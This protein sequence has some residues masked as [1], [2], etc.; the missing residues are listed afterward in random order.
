MKL[1]QFVGFGLA[2]L[3]LVACESDSSSGSGDDSAGRLLNIAG[4]NYQTETYS[5]V[6]TLSGGYDFEPGETV[7]FSL[8]GIELGTIEAQEELT[9]FEL[10][11]ENYGLPKTALDVRLQLRSFEGYRQYRSAPFRFDF[12]VAQGGD[13]SGIHYAANL[14]R[15][16]LSMD[17][18]QNFVNGI[19]LLPGDWATVLAEATLDLNKP[20]WEVAGLMD[21][22]TVK[23][24]HTYTVPW[25]ADN[26]LPL[27][28]LYEDAGVFITG[29]VLTGWTSDELYTDDFMRDEQ[30]RITETRYSNSTRSVIYRYTYDATGNLV[31]EERGTQLYEDNSLSN[32][33]IY[34]Y[35]F[36]QYAALTKYH[37]DRYDTVTNGEFGMP[38][39]QSTNTYSYQDG[40]ALRTDRL[41]ESINSEGV[42]SSAAQYD[43]VY[44]EN[45]D[46]IEAVSYPVNELGE[47]T[48]DFFGRDIQT[49]DDQGRLVRY[50][51]Q[52]T[53]V[54]GEPTNVTVDAYTYLDNQILAQGLESDGD[55]TNY[56]F[57]YNEQGQLTDVVYATYN[58]ADEEISAPQ[59][60]YIQRGDDGRFAHCGTEGSIYVY[61]FIWNEYGIEYIGILG[62]ATISNVTYG[63]EGEWLTLVYIGSDD[64]VFQYEFSND[65]LSEIIYDHV[66]IKDEVLESTLY[67]ASCGIYFL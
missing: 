47:Q 49:F 43:Y 1:L 40:K 24:I 26:A 60:N 66:F 67:K 54:D 10:F 55:Y 9:L 37:Y 4:V 2:S 3:A 59:K 27:Q 16:L 30:G 28:G 41:Y 17:D 36:N 39:S 56:E 11:D 25:I 22:D 44:N 18:D 38:T 14:T 8:G 20:L 48:G 12:N 52:G 63:E 46:Q 61:D 51:D 62:D 64:Y 53:F 13:A 58:S 45:L 65:A 31:G 42:V 15:L 57:N 50:E 32:W 6:T 19:N 5:G 23:F 21:R 34:D 33:Y 35:E 29:N 7:T